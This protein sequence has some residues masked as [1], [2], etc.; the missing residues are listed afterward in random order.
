MTRSAAF[1]TLGCPGMPLPEVVEVAQT[2]GFAGLELRA[3][4]GE[5]VHVGIDSAARRAASRSLARAGTEVLSIA[6]YVRVCDADVT[7][8]EVVGQAVAHAQLANDLRARWLRVLPGG[9]TATSAPGLQSDDD[10]RAVRRL[11]RICTE[12]AGLG[13]T[14]ALETHDSHRRG[15]DVMRLLAEPRCSGVEVVWDVL[16]TWLGGESATTS[17]TTIGDRLAYVQ[18]KDVVSP[19]DLTPLPPPTGVLHLDDVA[20][21]LRDRAYAG[22]LSWEYELAW[23]PSQPPLADLA[24]SVRAWMAGFGSG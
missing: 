1:S 5:P 2:A 10:A 7:D 14:V 17:A 18:V 16:H 22:W 12:I 3:A 20:H 9:S 4:T 21:A 19:T 6:S 8:D 15:A 13:V 11:G 24:T 23:N